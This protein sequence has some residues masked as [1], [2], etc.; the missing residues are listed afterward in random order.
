MSKDL[1]IHKLL[2]TF[3]LVP[4][5]GI[6]LV[7][8][9]AVAAASGSIKGRVADRETKDGLPGANIRVMGTSVGAST[10]LDGNYLIHN[11]PSG[12]QKLIV[13]YVGYLSDTVIVSVLDGKTIEKNIFL[14]PTAVQAKEVIV[15]AQAQGQMQAINQQLSA[16]Q[17]VNVVSAAKIQEL[18]DF[19]AAQAIGRLPGVSTLQSS[20]EANK[21]V[22]RGIAPQYNLV[23]IDGVS[24]APTGEGGGIQLNPM[25]PPT[26]AQDR[27]VD[28]T[29]ITS[30]MI[31][32]IEV[33]K[34]LTPDMDADA[35]GGYVNMQLRE[36]PSGFHT[37]FQWQLGY[38]DKTRNF[39]NYKAYGAVSDRFF[40]DVLGVYILANAEQYD[41][42]ADNF[43]AGYA[44]ARE[45]TATE[46]YA[47]VVVTTIGLN[48]HFETR[49]RY[50]ANV[51][52]DYRLPKGS[53]TAIN[54]F[55]RLNSSEEDY[56]TQHDLVNK[57]LNFNLSIDHR[58]ID[59]AINSLQGKYDFGI[60]SIDGGASNSY[61]RH[62]VP[63]GRT[64][65]FTQENAIGSLQVENA[66]PEQYNSSATYDSSRN[67]LH[68]FGLLTQDYKENDQSY[69][70]NIKVPFVIGTSASGFFKFGGVYRYNDRKNHQGSANAFPYY[71]NTLNVSIDRQFP[72]LVVN[73]ANGLR[74][75]G[76]NFSQHN[77]E[78][79]GN[80]L[81][82]RFG[83]LIW[84]P[85]SNVLDQILSY[86][87]TDSTLKQSGRGDAS[88][89]WN[90]GPY[91]E[92]TNN[93]RNVERYYAGYAMAQLNLGMNLL[94]VGG[95][96]YEADKML[97]TAYRIHD[98]NDPPTQTYK[99]VTVYPQNY[100]WLPM[101]QIRY[102]PLDGFDL[103]YSYTQ[104]LARPDFTANSPFA[105]SDNTGSY[106]NAGKPDLKPALSFN[107]DVMISYH[108]NW[109]GLVTIGGFYKIIKDL[110]YF[111]SYQLLPY[112]TAPGY[113]TLAQFSDMH[114][115]SG[116]V[117]NTWEND[118]YRAFLKGI[119]SDFQTQLWYLPFPLNG[120]VL[121]ANYTH[122]W[123]AAKYPY[124]V[125]GGSVRKP[126]LIDTSRTGRLLYQPNDILNS[127]IGYDYKGF[128]ARFS[129]LYQGATVS[130]I[131]PRPEQDAFTQPYLRMDASLRQK[132]PWNGLQL[133]FDINNLNSRANISTQPTTGGF[134]NEQFYGMTADLGIRFT[135]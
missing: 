23:A 60:L 41:R 5:I 40:G 83:D 35:I 94:I 96:R 128:S 59:A 107:H 31:Q 50:G 69:R 10:D 98:Q 73:P 84:A 58:N 127:Y 90:S 126:V 93:F 25:A 68:Y 67:Y 99:Q 4:M 86:V 11:V 88:A 30:N 113:D 37:D 89:G 95:A 100:Y 114:A 44:L 3:T 21:V 53:I 49:S 79:I 36:A 116:A 110:P 77:S 78:L 13:S 56:T 34:T 97:F 63:G 102:S 91:Q 101:I 33:Y 76:Y 121:G 16:V 18:P 109:V 48:R 70:A 38:V 103:R 117:L 45:R 125:V 92:L 119:E 64:F 130:I 57:A 131:G 55:S 65:T 39:K 120:I 133:Y 124:V 2:E 42:S 87:S 46:E 27:S 9:V 71:A 135:H 104:S 54:M 1:G 8:A 28:L 24:M 123:A 72:Q 32:S 12:S 129:V 115:I 14:T 112:H 106:I 74:I 17:I 29:M 81:D 80:F 134:E 62:Y 118:P 20:G 51:I 43:N 6:I 105:N 47:P 132:L 15:Q 19:N 26:T 82:G 85:Q 52:L 108:S 61:S 75:Y 122:I 111:T 22:I 66:T 7:F